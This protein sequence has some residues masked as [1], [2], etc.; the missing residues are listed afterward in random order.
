ME[1]RAIKISQADNVAVAVTGIPRGA[2]VMI[3]GDGMVTAGQDIPL[4][5]KIALA[6]IALGDGVIRY[7]EVICTAGA[8]IEPGDWVH[9]HNTRL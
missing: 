5:H 9:R 3:S 1:Y 4:G 6:R 8:D 7:G 2:G